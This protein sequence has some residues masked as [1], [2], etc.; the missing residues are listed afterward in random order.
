MECYNRHMLDRFRQFL[1]EKCLVND[2]RPIVAGVSGGADS[3]VL[4]N[5]L[6]LAGIEVICAHF[7]HQLRPESASERQLVDTLAGTLG[8][9]FVSGKAE[10]GAIRIQ[11]KLSL[12]E[13]ARLARYGFLFQMARDH[14]AQA[15]AVGHTADD[16]AET[17]LMHILRGSG[18]S[19]LRG[20]LPR[21]ILAQWD[22]GLPLIRP[23]LSF[24]RSEIENYCAANHLSPFEDPSN[25]DP[26][27]VRNRIRR[28][29][30]PQLETFNPGIRAAL[31]SMGQSVETDEELLSELAARAWA[32][33]IRYDSNT[34]IGFATSKFV[35]QP[36]AMQNRLIRSAAAKIDPDHRSLDHGATRRAIAAAHRSRGSEQADLLYGIRLF[37]ETDYLWLARLEDD[38]PTGHWPQV[39]GVD[40]LQLTPS[41]SLD[42]GEGWS[43]SASPRAQAGKRTM[44]EVWLKAEN[45][46]F[47]LDI[48]TR[49]RGERC[50]RGEGDAPFR[51]VSDL[52]IAAKIPRRARQK[53][54]LV[55][56]HGEV[57][58]IPGLNLGVPTRRPEAALGMTSLRLERAT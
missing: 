54:P 21:Q 56:N 19:G 51:S 12:E 42:L 41:E 6:K 16:Q 22:A 52:M 46:E 10:V 9:R 48:R 33:C 35:A 14:N 29:L 43:L 39:H 44:D 17:I 1:R 4:V 11:A 50:R 40:I 55:L 36:K 15:V 53:W 7:D 20:M 5:L 31:V 34:A 49:S 30:I 2:D 47:P 23:L 18:L 25:L 27:I 32:E 26:S 57:I 8:V 24:W 58:W 28:K 37:K 3:Q 38:L 45:L 13:A